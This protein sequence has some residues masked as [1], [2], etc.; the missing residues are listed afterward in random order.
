MI[1][2]RFDGPQPLLTARHVL[3]LNIYKCIIWRMDV[4]CRHIVVSAHRSRNVLTSTRRVIGLPYVFVGYSGHHPAECSRHYRPG[5]A[6]ARLQQV[7]QIG[8]EVVSVLAVV[9]STL[10]TFL[11]YAE[12]F[13]S[14]RVAGTQFSALRRS[15]DAEIA[16]SP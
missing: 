1:E 15:I 5:D 11:G 7:D 3:R 6:G 4:S 13:E 2:G 16:F 14:H 10:Q 12:P 9:A 8:L